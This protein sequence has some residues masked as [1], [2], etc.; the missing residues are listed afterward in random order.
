[1]NITIR[2][3]IIWSYFL[4]ALIPFFVFVCITAYLFLRQEENN[5]SDYTD[6]MLN[7]VKTSIDVYINTIEKTSNY[8]MNEIDGSEFFYH[9]QVDTTWESEKTRITTLLRDIADTHPE[10]AGILIATDNDLYVSTGMTRISKDS[11]TEEGWYKRAHD[12]PADI[13]IISNITGRNIITNERYNVDDVFSLSK[14]IVDPLTNEVVGVILLDIKH[15]IISQSIESITLGERGFVFV[16]D[17]NNNVVYT[18]TNKI[19]YRVNPAWLQMEGME[20]ITTRINDEKYQIRQEYSNYTGW[21][22]VGVFSLDE[23][24]GPIYKILYILISCLAVSLICIITFSLKISQSITKPIIQLKRLMKRAE[25]GDLS[26]RFEVKY[27]DEVSELGGNFNQMINRSEELIAMV[28]KE[29]QNKRSAELKVLQ[30]QIKPHFLYNTL[31]TINWMAREYEADD[32]VRVVDALTSMY[33][34]GLSNGKDYITLEEEIRYVSNYLYIQK[35]RYRSKLNYEI[36]EDISLKQYEVP[37]LVL[38]PLIENAIYHGI[39]AKRGDGHLLIR[40]REL[41]G[42]FMELTVEDDG[43]GMTEEQVEELN[44]RLSEPFRGDENQSFGLFYIN[45][46]LRIRYGYRYSVTIR[47]TK[48]VGTTITLQIPK[49][50]I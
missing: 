23:L 12:H 28:Y 50:E 13:Q 31:D 41:E 30:E 1:M 21:K 32:I 42:N 49:K 14:A 15:D 29:Q 24:M 25:A 46:R 44:R 38:Q 22:I 9:A 17:N 8:I 20:A 16:I 27:Q 4:I 34:I 37:K 35:I 40:T 33:R 36:D 48:D 47:S 19:T 43:S 2:S 6:Q 26:V 7:Q 45:E 5:V 18:P 39:K 3:K 10:V 11:F